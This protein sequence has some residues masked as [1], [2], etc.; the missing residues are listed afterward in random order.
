MAWT[1]T[2]SCNICGKAKSEEATDWW[3][4]WEEKTSPTPETEEPIFKL[5]H[6]N[7]FLAHDGNVK[8]LC[9]GRCVQTQLD[10][11]MHVTAEE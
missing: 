1:E 6:W 4:A 8:H 3:L 9:G 10:R 5:T 7:S 11:W 2:F